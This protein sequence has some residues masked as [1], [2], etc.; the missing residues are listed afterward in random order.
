MLVRRV[1]DTYELQLSLDPRLRHRFVVI[2]LCLPTSDPLKHI[3]ANRRIVDVAPNP[4]VG[5]QP[6]HRKCEGISH[7]V[8]VDLAPTTPTCFSTSSANIKVPSK[9][10]Q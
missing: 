10:S 4:C 3:G 5:H 7:R 9:E 2:K 1:L 6:H 8:D